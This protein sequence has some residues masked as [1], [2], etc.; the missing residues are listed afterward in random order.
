MNMIKEWPPCQAFYLESLL[1][2]TSSAISSHV[3]LISDNNTDTESEFAERYYLDQLQ[4]I[5]QQAAAISRYFWPSKNKD[6]DKNKIF[7]ERA[8]YLRGHFKIKDSN[9]LKNRSVRNFIEHFDEN[10]D[11]FLQKPT[12]GVIIPNFIGIKPFGDQSNYHLFRAFFTDTQEFMILGESIQIQ[13]LI[14][15][16][17]RIDHIIRSN[18]QGGGVMR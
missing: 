11:L 1:T 13:P 4:N 14:D 5:I 9:I 3:H 7:I 2:I 12:H 15:E 16:I 8:K 17:M 18:I 10:L 6:K